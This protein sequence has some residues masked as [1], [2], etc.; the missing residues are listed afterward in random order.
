MRY[1]K[2]LCKK[3]GKPAKSK[4][5]YEERRILENENQ[6]MEDWWILICKKCNREERV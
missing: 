2:I 4:H 6:Y 3:C 5:E 1:F